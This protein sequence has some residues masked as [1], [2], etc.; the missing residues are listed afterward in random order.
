MIFFFPEKL[1]SF[2][3]VLFSFGHLCMD[4][5]WAHRKAS[6]DLQTKFDGIEHTDLTTYNLLV[7]PR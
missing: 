3:E 2:N 1:G 4:T 7:N 5:L 6:V